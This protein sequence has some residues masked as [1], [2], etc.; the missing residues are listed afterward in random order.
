MKKNS[1]PILIIL[2]CLSISQEFKAQT[3]INISHE[4]WGG[5]MSLPKPCIYDIDNDGRLDIL[6]GV[7]TGVLFHYEFTE[8]NSDSLGI[9]SRNFNEIS[10]SEMAAP[11]ISDIDQ[12]GLL[13]LVIGGLYG[14]CQFEQFA[15]NSYEFVLQ[16]SNFLEISD[17]YVVP[18]FADV[19]GDNKLDLLVSSMTNEIAYYEQINPGGSN[20][21]LVTSFFGSIVVE[22]QSSFTVQDID[23]NG[24]IDVLAG[25][26]QKI[27][28]YEQIAPGSLNYELLSYS[29]I[30]VE[31][32]WNMAPVICDFNEDNLLDLLIAHDNGIINHFQQEMSE[33]TVFNL[34]SLNFGN[35]NIQN[36][37]TTDFADIDNDGLIDLITGN[38][39][40]TLNIYE[41]SAPGSLN[42][43]TIAIN[44]Q[45]IVVD[46]Y[47]LPETADINNNGL[48]DLL[49]GCANGNIFH[50]EQTAPN[51]YNFALVTSSFNDID[52]GLGQ[53]TTPKLT[54]LDN[55]GLYD[56]IVGTTYEGE[57]VRYEQEE[58]NS[59]VFDFI[60]G[61]IPG[62][63]YQYN[64]MIE[65]IDFKNDGLKDILTEHN[66]YIR[67]YREVL[68]GSIDF[69][70][71]EEQFCG[72]YEEHPH[73]VIFDIDNNNQLDLLI[74]IESG[75]IKHYIQSEDS[76]QFVYKDY[77]FTNELDA[78]TTSTPILTDL[79][80]DGLLELIAGNRAGK[81]SLFTQ[82]FNNSLSF[83]LKTNNFSDIYQYPYSYSLPTFTDLD[84]NGL[85]DMII[86]LDYRL[87]WYEQSPDDPFQFIQQSDNFSSIYVGDKASPVFADIDHDGML[88]L[89]IG[90]DEGKINHFKQD[91]PFLEY[92]SPVTASFNNIDVGVNSVPFLCDID[93]NNL[94][95]LLIGNETGQ[96]YH[97]RQ[98]GIN[99]FEFELVTQNFNDIDVDENASPA[100]GD[101]NGDGL[102]D[103]IVG[104]ESGGINLYIQEIGSSANHHFENKQPLIKIL[105]NPASTFICI[106][107]SEDIS[108]IQLFDVRGKCAKQI[109]TEISRPIKVDDLDNGL[110][111]IK[112]KFQTKTITQ[113]IV[114][115]H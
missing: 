40:G 62:I 57:F 60:P 94:L 36:R 26:N 21:N 42:F 10:V 51:L 78:G 5:G 66:G 69:M 47:S 27:S 79:N 67:H 92:F 87:L 70:L 1:L 2:L 11:T 29:F 65:I 110:Y 50:Y 44:F 73:P 105:P 75:D 58:P 96:I 55:D 23:D 16:N 63:N 98:D 28:R 85:K 104:K 100:V 107:A 72:I 32:N 97:Y 25:H 14:L 15:L 20:F 90:N 115:Q 111:L 81:L 82:N 24:R 113:K 114:I 56:L 83:D 59:M 41:Q 106:D 93:N 17:N 8:S 54:D 77:N 45:G 9:I 3:F 12:D 84:S 18:V 112:V 34:E 35:F 37:A 80:G 52:I 103:L 101:I 99:S 88:D 76:L 86:G 22:W 43:N 53:N 109:K 19:D 91:A 61:G 49:I 31:P 64:S 89:L 33:S 39:L 7:E 108:E 48:L 6:I 102:Q 46:Y 4:G 13:D 74:G 71:E 68:P 95:D 30:G 38:S